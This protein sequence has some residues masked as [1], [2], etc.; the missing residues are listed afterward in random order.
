MKNFNESFLNNQIHMIFYSVCI[1]DLKLK[2]NTV[3]NNFLKT[4]I[5]IIPYH[6]TCF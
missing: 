5:C 2:H 3:K 6:Y 1:Y 4:I